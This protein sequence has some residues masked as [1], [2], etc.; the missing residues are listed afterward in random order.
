M[1]LEHEKGLRLVGNTARLYFWVYQFSTSIR[2]LCKLESDLELC[3]EVSDVPQIS[4]ALASEFV[5]FTASL[6]F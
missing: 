3:Y 5:P 6:T 1:Q 4:G 2:S